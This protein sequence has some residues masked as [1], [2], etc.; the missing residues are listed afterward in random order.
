MQT[1][2]LKNVAAWTIENIFL[3]TKWFNR[4]TKT[5]ETT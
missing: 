2:N 4:T 3:P 1:T 5:K